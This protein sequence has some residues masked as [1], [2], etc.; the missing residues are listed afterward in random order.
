MRRRDWEANGPMVAGLKP[1]IAI[2]RLKKFQ[3]LFEVWMLSFLVNN[4]HE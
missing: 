3:Q 4:R 2:D 1:E